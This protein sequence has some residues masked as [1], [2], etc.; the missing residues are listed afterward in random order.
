MSPGDAERAIPLLLPRL[1]FRQLDQLTGDLRARLEAATPG[2][3]MLGRGQEVALP[4][5][6]PTLGGSSIRLSNDASPF[7]Y[8]RTALRWI[9]WSQAMV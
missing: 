5:Y 7:S 4:R 3:H 6:S 9:D 2:G 1:V 8:P